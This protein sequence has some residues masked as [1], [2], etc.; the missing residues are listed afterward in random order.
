[1]ESIHR[2][3]VASPKVASEQVRLLERAYGMIYR[4]LAMYYCVLCTFIVSTQYFAGIHVR[5]GSF[6]GGQRGSWSGRIRGSLLSSTIHSRTEC[7]NEQASD[8]TWCAL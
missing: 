8:E 2:R 1:M 3:Q 4:F 7:G 6:G 5:D